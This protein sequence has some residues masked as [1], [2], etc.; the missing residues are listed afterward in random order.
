[1]SQHSFTKKSYVTQKPTY[2]SR[3]K[4]FNTE[5]VKIK[6][7]FRSVGNNPY[8][9]LLLVVSKNFKHVLSLHDLRL[10]KLCHKKLFFNI[11]NER[12]QR[13]KSKSRTWLK[14]TCLVAYFFWGCIDISMIYKNV[15]FSS[16]ILSGLAKRR[17]V[18]ATISSTREQACII[19][20]VWKKRHFCLLPIV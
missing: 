16:R 9:L 2:Q 10:A 3:I 7:D 6:F 13:P 4:D 8:H 15:C 20:Y 18:T 14:P 19:S 17:L 11:T 12:R 5:Q 1:M